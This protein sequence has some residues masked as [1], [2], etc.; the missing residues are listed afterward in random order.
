[1]LNYPIKVFID[2]NI[3]D[4]SKY[5]IEGTSPLSIL[6]KFADNKKVRLYTSRIVVGEALNHIKENIKKS[7]DLLLKNNKEMR[8]LISPSLIKETSLYPYF[9][10]PKN[11]NFENIAADKFNQYLNELGFTILDNSNIDINQIVED[12]FRLKP[13]FENNE[14]KK[15]EFPD[16]LMIAKIKDFFPDSKPI[17][18]VSNDKGF[19]KAFEGVEGYNCFDKLN[20]LFDLINKQDEKSTYDAIKLQLVNESAVNQIKGLIE[21][22]IKDGNFEIDGQD[23]DRKGLC[24]GFDYDEASIDLISGMEIKLSSVDDVSDNR[25][26]VTIDC[27]ADISVYCEYDDYSN[28][29]WDSEEKEYVYVGR[30]QVSEDHAVEFESTLIFEV[31]SVGNEFDFKLI[32]IEYDL[33]MDQ[34]TRINREF[35]ENDPRGDWEAEMMDALEEYHRH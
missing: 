6:R 34:W 33:Q 25:V 14:K 32:E 11:E 26:T 4:G 10:I 19:S 13:P 16:A 5:H 3:F 24:E 1:M 17:W 18:I 27:K 29:A 20:D 30:G 15:N 28:S 31:I 9:E 23:C 35:I 7:H 2:T 21:E 12:Y 8:N 22:K